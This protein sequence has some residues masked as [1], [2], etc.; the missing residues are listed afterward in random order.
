MIPECK[1]F[2]KKSGDT[3]TGPLEIEDK[4]NFLG[5]KK[6]R[7][8]NGVEYNANFGV[9]AD[10]SA[11]VEL[12]LNSNTIGR[13]DI[14]PD[15]KIKNYKTG[16][17]LIEEDEIYYKSGDRIEYLNPNTFNVVGYLTTSG[18]EIHFN[19]TTSKKLDKISKINITSMKMAIRKPTGGY[20]IAINTNFSS[21]IK[22]IEIVN[23]NTIHICLEKTDGFGETNN[24]PVSVS[25]SEGFKLE[26]N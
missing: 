26:L 23:S 9:G 11:S 14:R 12:S 18:K 4:N 25:N 15:G 1:K 2:V 19:I 3:M 17:I 8:V 20:I 6:S 24:I 22:S 21:Y 13:I 5:V 7:I 16:K 10:G